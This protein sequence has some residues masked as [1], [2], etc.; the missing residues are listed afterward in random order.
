MGIHAN[1][2][3]GNVWLRLIAGIVIALNIIL[4]WN[5]LV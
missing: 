4:L 5:T 1:T 3:M 2:P